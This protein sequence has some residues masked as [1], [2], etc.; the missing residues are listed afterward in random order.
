MVSNCTH[1][2]CMYKYIS[3]SDTVRSD[4]VNDFKNQLKNLDSGEG[5]EV[6]H[7]KVVHGEVRCVTMNMYSVRERSSLH[8]KFLYVI[9]ATADGWH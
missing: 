6:V 4:N 9:K 3:F 1:V 7:G 8:Y 5:D 2:D